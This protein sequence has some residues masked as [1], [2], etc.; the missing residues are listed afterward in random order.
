MNKLKT[1]KVLMIGNSFSEDTVPHMDGMAKAYGLEDFVIA[2]LMIGGCPL[3]LHYQNSKNGSKTYD[4]F[5][6]DSKNGEWRIDR[7]KSLE[8]GI[9]YTDWDYITLQQVSPLS[10]NESTYNHEIDE[11][12][13]F[14]KEKATN[15]N[16]KFVWN[17]TWAYQYGHP[18]LELYENDQKSMY[19]SIITTVQRKIE[20]NCKINAVSPAGTSIQNARTSYLGDSFNRD[21]IHLSLGLGRYISGLTLFCLLT[22]CNPH[23]MT[24][25]LDEMTDGEFEVAK[26]SVANAL[27]QKYSVTN[28]KFTK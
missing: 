4:F 18:A 17:M 12:L 2:T 14:F 28:S 22:N 6:Y 26:E 13:D 7:Q 9:G 21:G 15:K 3:S 19:K 20:T 16:V 23:E 10:G 1:L 25:K 24:F 11:L 8:E 27:K 5:Y